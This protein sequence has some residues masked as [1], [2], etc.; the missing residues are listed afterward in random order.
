MRAYAGEEMPEPEAV[1]Y[2]RVTSVAVGGCAKVKHVEADPARART[3]KLGWLDEDAV[4]GKLRQALANGGC[5]AVIRN[6]VGMAQ[7]TYLRLRDALKDDGI[8]AELFHA[9]FPFGRRMEIENAVLQRFGKGGGPAERDKR[10]LVATQVVEQSLD[11]DFDIMVSD[12]APVDLVLQRAGRLHR[13]E[14]GPR[15]TGLTDARVW[16]IEPGERDGVPDF[17]VSGVVYSPHVLFRSLL[18]LRSDGLGTRDKFSL[19][20]EIDVLVEQVYE[21][22]P[23]PD[24]LSAAERE[25]WATTRTKHQESIEREESEAES[26]QIKKPRFRG[27]L[28]RMVQEPREEDNHDLHPAHQALTRLTRPTVSLICLERDDNGA[29]RLPHDNSPVPTLAIRKMS[30]GGF[31]DIGRLML[32]EVT[33]AHWGVIK[34]LREAPQTPP[35]WVDVGMLCRHHLIVFTRGRASLGEYELSLDHFLGLTIT[36]A[37]GEGEDE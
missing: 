18:A 3:V 8:M 9:R 2:P 30:H 22:S 14:R 23:A 10:V 36:R 4:A 12:V 29:Y 34:Q 28:A 27:V 6:T 33:S 26:R 13:H 11:L 35:E 15:P 32:A 19:P 37:S 7:E 17:G 5:A 25:F 21:D 16:L 24:S 31:E 20:R 1:P